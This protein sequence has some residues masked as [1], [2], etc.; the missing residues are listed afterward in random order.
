MK[1]SWT[2]QDP[3]GNELPVPTRNV[4]DSKTSE[5][6]VDDELG[7]ELVE[8]TPMQVSETGEDVEM[9]K[10]PV[11]KSLAKRRKMQ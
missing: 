2:I 1:V 8:D 5:F 4:W 6:N 3:E 10:W 9:G 7:E 11:E